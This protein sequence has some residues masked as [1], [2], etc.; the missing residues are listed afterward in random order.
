M[1]TSKYIVAIN[2]DPEA[3]IF[4]VADYGITGDLFEV[5]PALIEEVKKIKNA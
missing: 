5:V 4:Q 2:K 3:P 1:R